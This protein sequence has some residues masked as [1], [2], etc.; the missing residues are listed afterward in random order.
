[1]RPV[2]YTSGFTRAGAE[3]GAVVFDYRDSRRA[4]A[5]HQV[6]DSAGISAVYIPEKVIA[7]SDDP[8]ATLWLVHRVT[9][10]EADDVRAAAILE[11]HGLVPALGPAESR[12]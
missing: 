9:V 10:P 11:A 8:A 5:A 4:W 7:V 1:V 12:A 6:L 2:V 3:G